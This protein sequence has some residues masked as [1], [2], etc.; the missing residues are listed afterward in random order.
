MMKAKFDATSKSKELIEVV[1]YVNL[2]A[3][4]F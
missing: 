1:I 4:F 2:I 3:S